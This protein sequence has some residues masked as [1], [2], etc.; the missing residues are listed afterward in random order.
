M[1][2]SDIFHAVQEKLIEDLS[3]VVDSVKREYESRLENSWIFNYLNVRNLQ[4]AELNTDYKREDLE[5]FLKKAFDENLGI[6]KENVPELKTEDIYSLIEII[7]NLYEL[8]GSRA[9]AELSGLEAV[10]F[11]YDDPKQLVKEEFERAR[12]FNSKEEHEKWLEEFSENAKIILDYVENNAHV[13]S[14]KKGFGW[15]IKLS[16]ARAYLKSAF[17]VKLNLK[18]LP[19]DISVSR[20]AVLDSY[21]KYEQELIE[22]RYQ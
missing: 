13:L 14:Q 17:G 2:K 18:K 6:V 4:P 10:A 1:E 7:G 20:G 21:K 19:E 8:L 11:K 12:A 16:I 15:K 9:E 22:S 5:G 3:G